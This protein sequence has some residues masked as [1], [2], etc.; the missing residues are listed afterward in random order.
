MSSRFHCKIGFF[1]DPVETE[2][3]IWTPV[4]VEKPYYGETVKMGWNYS[5]IQDST[6]TDI[7]ISNTVSIVMDTYC[8]H[9]YPKIAYVIID[10]IKWSV[11][12]IN[13]I[14]YPRLKF[15]LGGLYNAETIVSR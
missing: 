6:N 5:Q 13:D 12:S 3:G 15:T 1:I 8:S 4:V 11:S 7:K 9:N 10:G 2:P 14:E